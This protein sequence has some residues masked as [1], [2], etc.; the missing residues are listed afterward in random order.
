MRKVKPV[1]MMLSLCVLSL[2]ACLTDTSKKEGLEVAMLSIAPS[3]WPNQ[4][5]LTKPPIIPSR[6]QKA[7]STFRVTNNSAL[8]YHGGVWQVRANGLRFAH[9]DIQAVPVEP[10]QV[11][12]ITVVAEFSDS[13]GY[14]FWTASRAAGVANVSISLSSFNLAPKE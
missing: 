2:S 12:T 7:T 10:G 11:I 1:M 9:N 8:P 4:G 3:S 6:A 14:E 5:T 13:M